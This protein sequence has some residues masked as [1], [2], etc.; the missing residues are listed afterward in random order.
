MRD[1]TDAEIIFEILMDMKPHNVIE[2][3]HRGKP[4]AIN[5]A[6]RSRIAEMRKKLRPEG[7]DIKKKIDTNRQATYKLIPIGQMDLFS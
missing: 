4:Y 7:Y 5:W 2:I 1:K 3:M 6:V